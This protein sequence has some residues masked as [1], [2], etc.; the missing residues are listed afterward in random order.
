MPRT[1]TGPDPK[2]SEG[3]KVLSQKLSGCQSARRLD[4]FSIGAARRVKK[5]PMPAG[6]ELAVAGLLAVEWL[7]PDPTGLTVEGPA[8]N[9]SCARSYQQFQVS[10][11]SPACC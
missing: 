8:E 1:P 10:R 9:S 11:G 7:D 4:E 3:G 5:W 2:E 6:P